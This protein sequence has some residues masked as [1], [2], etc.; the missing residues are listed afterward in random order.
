M[1][2]SVDAYSFGSLLNFDIDLYVFELRQRR[3][4]VD[5][6]DSLQLVLVKVILIEYRQESSS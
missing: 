2:V 4:D 3:P 6:E 1:P 5:R